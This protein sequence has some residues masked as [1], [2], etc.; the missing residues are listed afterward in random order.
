[1]K[2]GLRPPKKST[3]RRFEILRSNSLTILNEL[4]LYHLAALRRGVPTSQKES[5]FDAE[6]P[7]VR[8]HWTDSV[9]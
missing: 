4:V 3:L 5:L 6:T 8:S 1:M 9:A 2:G 7:H